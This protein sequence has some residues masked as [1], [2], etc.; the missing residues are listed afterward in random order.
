MRLR[1]I[2]AAAL[3]LPLLACSGS[4]STPSS[5]STP[6]TP[7]MTPPAQPPATPATV[8]TVVSGETDRGVAGASV[9]VSGQSS[10]GGAVTQSAVTDAAGQF[11]LDSRLVLSPAP[12]MDITAAGF[13]TRA[14]LVRSGETRITLWPSTSTTGL[15]ETFM[16]TTA[17]SV[18]TCPATNAPS[19]VLRRAALAVAV[20]P[21]V[22]GPGIRDN[23][24]ARTAHETA[25]SRLNAATGGMPRYELAASEG[26][27]LSVAADV[28]PDASGCSSSS[29]VTSILA[30][31]GTVVS[32]RI[33]YCNGSASR[34]ANLILHEL[35]HTLGLYHSSSS[36]DAMFCTGA[37]PN[38]F[39]ARERLLLRLARQRRAGTRWPDNDRQAST[40]LSAALTT[41]VIACGGR[42]AGAEQ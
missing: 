19:S 41:E 8:M 12:Q 10:S 7:G 11:T 39:S 20:V 13:L 24:A 40:T 25:I 32:A 35:G 1:A 14:T 28:E 26:A 9:S 22:M 16:A 3:L 4:S 42:E 30:A 29:A 33:N 17:Y 2:A 37:R 21:V 27:S 34:D 18:S 23:A 38:E 5:P 6:T 36:S 31:N 15:D